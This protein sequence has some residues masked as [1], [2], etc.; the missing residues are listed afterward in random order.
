MNLQE[1]IAASPYHSGL[2]SPRKKCQAAICPRKRWPRP[3][4]SYGRRDCA[5]LINASAKGNWN[6]SIIQDN[7]ETA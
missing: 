5:L 1:L 3:L 6:L 4:D 7:F 2:R